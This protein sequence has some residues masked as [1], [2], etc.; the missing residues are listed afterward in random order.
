MIDRSYLPF[1]S[2][3]E[4]QDTGMQKWMGF[5]LSE[6]TTALVDDTN[7]MTYHT[8]LSPEQKLLLLSQLYFNQINA[9]II[10]QEKNELKIY[11][12]TIPTITP[13]YILIKTAE[14]HKRIL[15]NDITTIE[16]LEDILYESA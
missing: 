3:R 15:L 8:H 10:A 9:Q 1:Q 12:G 6:H 2:A 11:T 16:L 5:F 14:G 7:S 13:Q 4:Y